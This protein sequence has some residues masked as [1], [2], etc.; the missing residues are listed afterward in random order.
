M[1]EQVPA[2][3]KATVLET[4]WSTQY[5]NF[6]LRDKREGHVLGEVAVILTLEDSE[7]S[8]ERLARTHLAP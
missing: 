4:D 8:S 5:I 2:A 3:G 7:C 6:G 1:L